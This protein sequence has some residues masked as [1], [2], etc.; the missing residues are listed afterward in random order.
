MSFVEIGLLA[1]FFLKSN[2]K[3]MQRYDT[4][5]LLLPLPTVST[6]YAHVLLCGFAAFQIILLF[7]FNYMS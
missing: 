7:Y 4:Y 5:P 3:K 1:A 2:K 6:C